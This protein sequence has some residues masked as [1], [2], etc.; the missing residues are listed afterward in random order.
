MPGM[1][2]T[3]LALLLAADFPSIK[4]ILA[5]GFTDSLDGTESAVAGPRLAKPY[6]QD[7]VSR[8]IAASFGQQVPIQVPSS[9]PRQQRCPP[10]RERSADP[11]QGDGAVAVHR[12]APVLRVPHLLARQP[13]EAAIGAEHPTV[14]GAISVGR[15]GRLPAEGE[16]AVWRKRAATLLTHVRL[17]RRSTPPHIAVIARDPAG[18]GEFDRLIEGQVR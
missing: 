15:G 14:L 11:A 5:T 4:V 1:S 3:E 10:H 17:A 8:A 2:G 18:Y 12:F 13:G 7:Q 9:R 16:R 6:T